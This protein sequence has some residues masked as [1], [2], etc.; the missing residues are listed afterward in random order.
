MGI[1]AAFDNGEFANIVKDPLRVSQI[2]H[3]ATIEVT[4]DGTVGSAASA[5][6]LVGLS[7]AVSEPKEITINRPFLFL[8]RD[9][10]LKAILF[11]GKFSNPPKA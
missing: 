4:K 11:A 10:E 8:V 3:R 6:E 7:A 2:K 9:K 5:I 1:N